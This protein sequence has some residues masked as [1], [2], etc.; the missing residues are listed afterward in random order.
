MSGTIIIRGP[1]GYEGRY[2]LVNSKTDEIIKENNAIAW[3]PSAS[4]FKSEDTI[5]VEKDENKIITFDKEWPILKVDTG[6]SVVER[7]DILVR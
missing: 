4:G 6:S 1:I 3:N 5:I 7:P 2:F